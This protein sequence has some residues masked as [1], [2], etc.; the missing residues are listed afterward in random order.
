MVRVFALCLSLA[1]VVFGVVGV[2]LGAAHWLVALDFVA[3]AI[4]LALA[5]VLWHTQGRWSVIVAFGMATALVVLF[6]A[7]MAT[8][9]PPSLSWCIFGVGAAFFAVGCARAF[10]RGMYGGELEG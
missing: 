9:A 2:T 1:L 8:G 3:G 10:S 5:A 4:G 7:S 6:F